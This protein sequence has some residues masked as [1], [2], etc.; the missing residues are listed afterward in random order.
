MMHNEW[1]LSDKY[2]AHVHDTQWVIPEWQIYGTCT[3][4]T[5]SD[6]CT[7]W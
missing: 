7:G 2:M 6:T 5:V 4:H 1:Y 3:W